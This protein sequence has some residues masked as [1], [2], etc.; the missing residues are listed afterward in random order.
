VANVYWFIN[1]VAGRV[2]LIAKKVGMAAT[3]PLKVLWSHTRDEL[4]LTLSCPGASGEPSKREVTDTS[5]AFVWDGHEFAADF[6][7][8]VKG[9][10]AIWDVRPDTSP[11]RCTVLLRKAADQPRP[12]PQPFQ[13]KLRNVVVDWDRWEEDDD[14]DRPLPKPPPPAPD[15]DVA[16]A[17]QKMATVLTGADAPPVPGV[18]RYLDLSPLDEPPDGVG[19]DGAESV[20]LK[21]WRELQKEERM[22]TMALLWNE[23]NASTREACAIRLVTIL[24]GGDAIDHQL[25]AQIKGGNVGA[26]NLDTSVYD[27]FKRPP[28]WIKAFKEFAPERQVSVMAALFQA[29][30]PDERAL[31]ASTFM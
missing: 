10:S 26:L 23:A 22:V 3:P 4:H 31:V 7:G 16:E 5:F 13:Q 8:P 9:V 28:R 11:P 2:H 12:W 17:A 25:E 15:P 6:F 29:L 20:W 14:D 30:I 18:E 1:T 21:E 19:A 24:R 27:A